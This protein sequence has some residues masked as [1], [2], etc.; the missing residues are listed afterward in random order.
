MPCF[1]AKS[2]ISK[3]EERKNEKEICLVWELNLW[4]KECWKVYVYF[5]GFLYVGENDFCFGFRW[6]RMK[7]GKL[8]FRLE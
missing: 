7:E 8:R 3:K 5:C 6:I 4:K 1:E 2:E